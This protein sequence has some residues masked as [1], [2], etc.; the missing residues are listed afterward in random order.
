[1]L[2]KLA[3]VL[4]GAAV[5]LAQAFE[6]HFAPTENLEA[7]DVALISEA[8]ETIDMAAYVLTDFAVIEAL[9]LAADRGVSVRIYR[10]ADSHPGHAD[11]ADAMVRLRA[12]G[13]EIRFKSPGA[14]LMHLKAYCVDNQTLRF[15]AANFSH[16]GLTA[17]DNDLEITRGPDVCIAFETDFARMWSGQ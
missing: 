7:I 6:Q 3:I 16:S 17:Q 12:A 8:G 4:L 1:M 5:F 13:A 11:L 15:G 9:T 10:Q 14:P 2:E